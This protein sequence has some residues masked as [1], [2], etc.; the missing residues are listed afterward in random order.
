MNWGKTIKLLG[1]T[2]E[3]NRSTL[4][5]IGMLR[6]TT[7]LFCCVLVALLVNTS[8]VYGQQWLTDKSLVP[9]VTATQPSVQRPP[10]KTTA[11]GP[12]SSVQQ[13]AAMEMPSGA[14]IPIVPQND[15]GL[16]EPPPPL[17]PQDIPTVFDNQQPTQQIDV[18]DSDSAWYSALNWL[19]W[20]GW[21]NSAELGINGSTGNAESF[22]FQAGARFKR[23][24]DIN[25]MDLRL[26]HNR[27]SAASNETQNNALL[28]ADYERFF[29]DSPWTGFLKNGLE[30]DEFKAF[31]LRYNINAG[32][33]YRLFNTKDL[34]LKGRFGAGTS[35]EFGGPDNRWVPEALFGAD[36]EHQVNK[37]NKVIAKLDYFP[38][39]TDFDNFRFISDL[40]WEILLDESGNMSLKL[41]AMDRYDSTP[42][43]RKPNDL[44]YTALL[45]YKF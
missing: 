7:N 32:I 39:W 19:P 24:T 18:R 41:G 45:L 4:R 13:A 30:Y 44:N 27:T 34:Q 40:A 12:T 43:G 8:T 15:Q 33:G 21:V 5:V 37:R 29:G 38:E 35:R 23:K 42:N 10:N 1:K 16:L 31:D 14:P 28:Y 3:D 36:Y 6:I 11:A 26:T 9:S 17:V 20:D 25:L 22:S 2:I